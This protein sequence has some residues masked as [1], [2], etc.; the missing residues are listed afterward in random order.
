IVDDL[1]GNVL[2]LQTNGPHSFTINAG[3]T[4]SFA[5]AA[6][7][8]TTAG[9]DI[10]VTAATIGTLG[11]FNVGTG[12]LTLDETSS[13]DIVLNSITAKNLNVTAAGNISEASGAVVSI[14]NAATLNASTNNVD[15]TGAT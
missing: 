5:N 6:D 15:L 4:F 1:A 8:I 11:K 3:G 13:G 9:G 14:S 12:T 7:T 2:A 10:S